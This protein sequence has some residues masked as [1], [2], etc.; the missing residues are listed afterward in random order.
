VPRLH[1]EYDRLHR[2][3]RFFKFGRRWGD[4]VPDECL[5]F[6]DEGF[7]L[8]TDEGDDWPSSLRDA[9]TELMEAVTRSLKES[10]RLET[11]EK[12]VR[13]L[14][15]KVEELERQWLGFPSVVSTPD[16]CGGSPRL[17]RTRIPI[18]LLQQ[19]RQTG[20]SEAK[21][22]ASYPTL[23]AGD[24]AQAWGYVAAHKAEIDKEIEENERY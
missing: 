19:M 2:E 13:T 4:D 10:A 5:G 14:S 6:E 16:V 7:P 11:L 1:D 3:E 20:F 23:T 12:Q 24:L 21:I 22:L 17:V 15:A 18:W 8:Q 9:V